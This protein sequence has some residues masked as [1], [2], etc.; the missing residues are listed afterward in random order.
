MGCCANDDDADDD[1]FNLQRLRAHILLTS[2]LFV[3]HKRVTE[4]YTN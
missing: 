3:W 1:E 2:V 4:H